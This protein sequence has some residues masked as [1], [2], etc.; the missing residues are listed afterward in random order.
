MLH[1]K[2]DLTLYFIRHAE[3]TLNTTPSIIGGRSDRVPLTSLGEEQARKLGIRLNSR[4]IS[5]DAVYTSPLIRARRTCEIALQEMG[6]PL[7]KIIESE[8]LVEFT[9]G[10]WEGKNRADIYTPEMRAYIH[11]KGPHFTPPNGESQRM[12]ERRVSNWFE[13]TILA[14]P[15]YLKTP[16]TIGI[17]S[18]GLTIKCFLHYALS[19]D[20]AHTYKIALDNT[21][22]TTLRFNR[23]G[24]WFE[25]LNDTAHLEQT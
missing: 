6:Y 14:N 25:K 7:D 24:W 18:H 12:L 17:F 19:F 22:I 1:E 10:D 8:A 4:G 16:C 21:S 3:S 11:G 15:D 20:A 5:F 13:D 9:Q 2:T 23:L